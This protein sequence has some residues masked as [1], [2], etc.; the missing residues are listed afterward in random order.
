MRGSE[1]EIRAISCLEELPVIPDKTVRE[2]ARFL[3]AER[4]P[5]ENLKIYYEPQFFAHEYH[6]KLEGTVP[7]IL[8]EVDEVA[9]G[10]KEV[11]K[12]KVKPYYQSM[13]A[14]P[15]WLGKSDVYK[16]E[17]TGNVYMVPILTEKDPK[18][19]QKR[20]MRMMAPEVGYE[21]I[22]GD[23]LERLQEMYPGYEFLTPKPNES[24]EA[25][26]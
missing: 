11:T 19:R 7:D 5:G 16:S 6:G 17:T 15:I 21:V 23:D 4:Y 26:F 22:Y 3:L 10:F 20:V 25:I 2:Y 12:S 8:L 24:D 9:E 13:Q 1:G 18:S 14:L